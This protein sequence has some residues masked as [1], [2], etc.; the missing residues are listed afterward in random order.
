MVV[1]LIQCVIAGQPGSSFEVEIDDAAKV[2]KFKDAIKAK[3]PNELKDVDPD[4]LQIFLAK[5]PLEEEGGKEVV[6]VYRPSAK[7]M[8]ERLKWLPDEHRAALKLAKGESDDYI[9]ALMA[10]EQILGSKTL[11]TWFYTKN[12][13]ELPSSEQIHMLVKVPE[14]AGGDQ[15]LVSLL[16][17]SIQ[18]EN[19][20]MFN[21]VAEENREK[22][23]ERDRKRAE[24]NREEN[25]ERDRKRAE[26]NRERDRKRAEENRERDRKRAEENRERD[27]KQAKEFRRLAEETR[28][29]AEE[30]RERDRKRAEE[31][32]KLAEEIRKLAE[33]K[34]ELDR[35]RAQEIRQQ[36]EKFCNPATPTITDAQLGYEH[37]N[38]LQLKGL[39]SSAEET[40]G[41]DAF[42]SV[43]VQ[44]R[45]NSISRENDFD[46]FI[47]PYFSNA[48]DSHD[49]VF[50]NS[51]L[52]KW[53]PQS[54]NMF[55]NSN[56]DLN[57]DGFVTHR[58]MYHKEPAPKDDVSRVGT[59]FRF[60]T[61]TKALFDC[62]V[63]F[64]SKITNYLRGAP[65]GQVMRYIQ[66]VSPKGPGGA[67]L[68]NRK[69][70]WLIESI[71][72][73]VV[74]VTKAT[75]VMEGSKAL[76]RDFITQNLS[77]WVTRLTA[78]CSTLNVEVV[79]GDAFL[80]RG[81]FGR[82]FKVKRV[83]QD[84]DVLALKIVEKISIRRLFQEYEALV[85]AQDTGL[86]IRP[87]G[88]LQSFLVARRCCCLLSG[89]LYRIQLQVRRRESFL[90]CYGSSSAG[91]AHGDPRVPNM[92]VKDEQRL[93][94]DL[95]ELWDASP[96][97]M[98]N[99]AKILTKSILHV[100]WKDLLDSELES[101]I[102]NYGTIPP[103]QANLNLLA[104]KVGEKLE[105]VPR[106]DG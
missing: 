93:W 69:L 41:A 13:M 68:F 5:Q 19:A 6:P 31:T 83:G 12:N 9:N 21:K 67:V 29:L 50:V 42:W 36:F 63:L 43:E 100:S 32:R 79:E 30:N 14:G 33:E 20:R 44:A 60:G 47:T 28:K 74:R 102:N 16:S 66:H 1:A 35:K 2:S 81:A 15:E 71:N 18:E 55:G 61:A 87:V 89:S 22:N 37:L 10:E 64:E 4:K 57:P 90:T 82:V 72:G 11:A 59:S 96:S 98:Q 53:L 7:E 101:L 23:R 56:T 77:P 38:L 25:R 88:R 49:L 75:W 103:I 84:G 91:V 46:A 39:V 48:L 92:I 34:R 8:K 73:V 54:I 95:Y 17:M 58:G 51:E 40:V 24:E 76:F 99:D 85:R 97:H 105:K 80:G 94:I 3:K 62:L 86:V 78:A 70:F 26:E 52:Y 27:R 45:V 65:F 106:L 104:D